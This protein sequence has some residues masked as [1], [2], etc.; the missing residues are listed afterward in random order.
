MTI[1]LYENGFGS[2]LKINKIKI[3][4]KQMKEKLYVKKRSEMYNS[5][6][7]SNSYL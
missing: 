1:S 5:V 4:Q 6:I 3:Q 7:S 2:I